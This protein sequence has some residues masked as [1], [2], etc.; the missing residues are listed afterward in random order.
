MSDVLADYRSAEVSYFAFARHAIV[1]ALRRSGVGSGDR[2]AIPGFVCRDVLASIAVLGAEP[3]FYDVDEALRP[4]S[5]DGVPPAKAI[6]AVDYFGFPQDLVPFRA[7]CARTNA[8][9]IEDNAHGLFSRD[10]HGQLLG[11]RGDFGILSL[12]KTF[13]VSSGAALLARSSAGMSMPCIERGEGAHAL[14]FALSRFERRTGVP[15]FAAMR[16]TIRTVRRTLG[17]PAIESGSSDDE[18]QLPAAMAIGCRSLARLN[19]QDPVAERERRR[20]MFTRVLDDLR[21]M[22]GVH[23]LHERL[24]DHTVPYGVPFRVDDEGRPSLRAIERR[25]HVVVMQWPAL[26]TAIA[27]TAPAHYRNVWLVNFL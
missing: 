3:L 9:L 5:L 22:P 25:H 18:T 16:A 7:Y 13:H 8:R 19:D 15:V 11:L 27:A 14:R 2:V 20:A 24:D 6:I 12:R 26:P 17:K 21:H 4:D 1:E 23:P 10:E